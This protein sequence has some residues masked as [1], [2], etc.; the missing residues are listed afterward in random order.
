M[1]KISE[2]H[3]MTT[4]GGP[5]CM[6]DSVDGAKL[7]CVVCVESTARFAGYSEERFRAIAYAVGT[8][9]LTFSLPFGGRKVFNWHKVLWFDTSEID[10]TG[11][12]TV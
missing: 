9:Q 8:D 2:D 5:K 10:E 1:A 6:S 3:P 12:V 11:K 4:T 7:W